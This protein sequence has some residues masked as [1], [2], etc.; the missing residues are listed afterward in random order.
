MILTKN[1]LRVI[2]LP[3]CNG[4]DVKKMETLS[5]NSD[6]SAHDKG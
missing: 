1:A 5:T 2:L 6:S 4:D 3:K